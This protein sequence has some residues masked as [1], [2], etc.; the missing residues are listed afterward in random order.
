MLR[1]HKELRREKHLLALCFIA[2]RGHRPVTRAS[3]L[4]SS[5]DL[6]LWQV[7]LASPYCAKTIVFWGEQDPLQVGK[8]LSYL[9]DNSPNSICIRL[10]WFPLRS[11]PSFLPL[12]GDQAKFLFTEKEPSK[13]CKEELSIHL[14]NLNEVLS[15]LLCRFSR[16][17]VCLD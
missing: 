16:N 7:F 6:S 15:L 4:Y 12:L 3:S 9:Y 14:S 11:F 17:P 5:V 8:H 1:D 2:T 10:Q 13:G